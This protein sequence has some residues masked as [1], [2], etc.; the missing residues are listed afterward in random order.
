MSIPEKATQFPNLDMRDF[1]LHR[2][3]VETWRGM[4]FVHPKPDSE[5]LMQWLAGAQD[6][7]GPHQPD[8]LVEYAN[9]KQRH[10]IAANWKIVAENYIDGYHLAHLHSETLAM[11]DHAKQTSGFL[12]PHYVFY[13]PLAKAYHDQLEKA[14]PYPLIDHIA[15]EQLGAYV[16]LLFPNLGLSETESTWSTF[17][18]IP[19]APA[20]TVVE[21]RTKMMPMSSWDYI[22]QGLSSYGYFKG[23]MD[24]YDTGDA[25]DPMAS[26]DFMT[27]DIYAC[28]QQQKSLKSPYF[29]VGA[30]AK[31]LEDSVRQFQTIVHHYIPR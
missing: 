2:A 10:E 26:G 8:K 16:P 30:T 13:E 12:G 14:A 29:A 18:I 17:H 27:E 21:I 7:L 28:E 22:K 19:V 24:K 4:V 20:K 25:N 15:P 23:K 5:P 31:T 9:T 1:C 6:Y 3:S 11:Y